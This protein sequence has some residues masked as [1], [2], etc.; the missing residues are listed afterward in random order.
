MEESGSE[1]RKQTRSEREGMDM[2]GSELR[3]FLK[4][5]EE[6]GAKEG[7]GVTS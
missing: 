6:Q 2:K 4:G 5:I 7:E 3:K 1:H